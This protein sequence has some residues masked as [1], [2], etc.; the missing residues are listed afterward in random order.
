MNKGKVKHKMGGCGF[1][2]FWFHF[3]SG[4]TFQIEWF[5][6]LGWVVLFILLALELVNI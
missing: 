1:F 6:W 4:K 5:E 2:W 3:F